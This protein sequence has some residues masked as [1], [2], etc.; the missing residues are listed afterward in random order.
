MTILQELISLRGEGRLTYSQEGF[1]ASHFQRQES[2]GERKM[3]V[4]S[5]RKCFGLY[6]R[7]DPLGSLV[8]T[9][10]ESPA[11]Y[12]P[13]VRLRWKVKPLFSTRLT[14][15]RYSSK[16][17]LSRPYAEILSVRDIPSSRFLFQLAVSEP[18]TGETGYGLLPTPRA[19]EIV[20]HPM[21]AAERLKDRTGKKLNNLSS[22]AAFGLLSHPNC[23][24]GLQFGERR[25][26]RDKEQYDQDKE[27]ERHEQPS[28]FGGSGEAYVISDSDSPRFQAKGSEQQTTGITG[29]GLQK[30]ATDTYGE[31]L[32]TWLKNNGRE[33]EEENIARLDNGV[34]RS[35]C[36]RAFAESDKKRRCLMQYTS[37]DWP[38]LSAKRWKDFPT[39][40]PV[41]RRNDGLPFDVD[42]LA[43]PFTKWRQESIKAYGNAIVPQV[44]FEIFK[45]IEASIHS[46]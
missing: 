11:W 32:Q 5:G 19:M 34:E 16:N 39:Q 43:I 9:L 41:C 31:K 13:A 15:K 38:A 2:E 17:M 14:R 37:N 33:I 46:S 23:S 36:I 1:L 6:E 4:T 30:D 3:T 40:P 18:R 35:C 44:A 22:G 45:A 10:L 42:Y 28:R 12:N 24:R 25:D 29:G 26:I 7:Y 8:R 20:E 21:K 27:P